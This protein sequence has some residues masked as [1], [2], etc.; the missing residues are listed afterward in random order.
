MQRHELAG[1]FFQ[2][3]KTK[4]QEIVK[5]FWKYI[6]IATV[7]AAM[8]P[9]TACDDDSELGPKDKANYEANF[10]YCLESDNSYSTLSYR[11]SGKIIETDVE[12]LQLTPVRF[13]KPAPAKTTI[14]IAIDPTLV[15][16]YNAANGTDYVALTDVT[17]VNSVMTIAAG[18][19]LSA[20]S[21]KI[22][23]NGNRGFVEN[24][25]NLLLPVV[26]KAA[27]NGVSISKS[28]RVFVAFN[29]SANVVSIKDGLF[30]AG[31]DESLWE[32]KMK[33][34]EVEAISSIFTADA[35]T[36][37]K[38]EVDNSLVAGY[39]EANG[40]ELFSMEGVTIE[41]AVILPGEKSAKIRFN[42][43]EY[44]ELK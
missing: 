22:D 7:T 14:E 8:V 23:L 41:D 34:V 27:D 10:A 18:Q 24:G 4:N 42:V 16:E 20:D 39:N 32:E 15:D 30:Q 38:F 9:F 36:T 2:M 19:Y 5:K 31:E 6:A 29:Y 1:F 11:Y 37:I 43:P 3:Y 33:N 12:V 28:S 17:I 26:I 25:K 13:T 44:S 35:N 21:I 40:T